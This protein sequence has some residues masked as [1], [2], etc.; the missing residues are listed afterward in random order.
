MVAVTSFAASG[1]L[2]IVAEIRSSSNDYFL[3]RVFYPLSCIMMWRCNGHF[4]HYCGP[5]QVIFDST[6]CVQ[7][8]VSWATVTWYGHLVRERRFSLLPSILLSLF[9]FLL[10]KYLNIF[11]FISAANLVSMFG[12]LMTDSI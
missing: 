1:I 3:L 6:R 10:A 11:L 4:I 9:L 12:S 5:Y 8:G 7:E 2:P